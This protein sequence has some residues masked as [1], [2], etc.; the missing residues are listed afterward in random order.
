MT[1]WPRTQLFKSVALILVFLIGLPAP[2]LLA[3][4]PD[5][6]QQNFDLARQA[7]FDGQ[8]V[9]ARELLEELLPQIL[10][11]DDHSQLTGEAS[12]L[13]G[14]VYEGLELK[15]EAVFHYCQAK[16]ILGTGR[17][18]AGLDL[19][20][21]PWYA[22]PC[23]EKEPE[24][25][26]VAETA[27]EDLFQV[28][29]NG[30][31]KNF[32]A[33]NHQQAKDELE[34]LI[35]DLDTLS[36]RDT[37]KG[38][39]YLLAGAAYEKLKFREL[40]FKYF[41]QAKSILGQGRTIEGL[42]LKEYK[43]YRKDCPD[44]GVY[45]KP[46]AKKKGAGGFLGVLLGLAVLAGAAYL[47]YTKFIKQDEE[48]TPAPVYYENEYQA[49]TCWHASATAQNTTVTPQINSDYAPNP[50]FSNNYDDQSTCTI[51][52]E[53]IVHWSVGITITACNGLTRRDQVFVNDS[54]VLDVT[55][56]YSKSCAGGPGLT[57]FCHNPHDYTAQK[58][59]HQFEVAS[60]SGAASFTIRHKITF[61]KPSGEKVVLE[62][63]RTLETVIK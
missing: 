1:S 10:E 28:R 40:A 29:F 8:L 44:G 6:L 58:D 41:C 18:F 20:S 13:A 51:T 31:K 37:F 5:R 33:G 54:Q 22:E 19:E 15:V 46:A 35:A 12:L 61:T 30:A 59:F 42:K 17:T 45:A 56:T 3:Q 27:E 60:G 23:P 47:V 48:E 52:G 55:N 25:A 7:Y 4:E 49:W 53:N 32:F 62:T 57:D 63:N 36:G 38:E 39:V 24:V 16:E 21:L 50:S 2:A 43:I 9:L 11:M 34:K 14:A 26:V